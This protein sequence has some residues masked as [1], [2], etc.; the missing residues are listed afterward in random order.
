MLVAN[1]PVAA[2]VHKDQR[3]ARFSFHR[4]GARNEPRIQNARGYCNGA[5]EVNF[6]IVSLTA[7]E[8]LTLLK[9]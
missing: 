3:R 2:V 6:E 1:L 9:V 7:A 4:I 5:K 8:L